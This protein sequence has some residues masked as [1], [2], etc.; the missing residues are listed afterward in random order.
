MYSVQPGD[1][2]QRIARRRYGSEQYAD[3]IRQA[4]P[5][6]S[7]PL[8][9]G[10]QLIIPALPDTPERFNATAA[11]GQDQVT[12]LIDDV[13]VSVWD[14]I[15]I[16][17]TM[18]SMDVISVTAP[19]DADNPVHREVFRPF[20]YKPVRILIGG[21]LAFK[22]TM[23]GVRPLLADSSKTVTISAYSAPGVLEDC[24]VSPTQYPVE[25]DNATLRTIAEKLMQPF[26]LTVQ[27][28][29]DP[30]A[31]FE[32]VAIEPTQQ[33]MTFLT[34]LAQQR[35]LLITSTPGGA[36]LFQSEVT[37]ATP[38]AKLEQGE[39]PLLRVTPSFSEQ[40][41]YSHLT[42]IEWLVVGIAG[43]D[44]TVKNEKLPGVMRPF[45][46]SVDDTQ[47][48]DVQSVV[49][50][51]AGRMLANAATYGIEVATWRDSAHN[52]WTPNTLTTLQAPGAMVYSRYTFLVRS[53]TL[54]ASSNGDRVAALTL[55]LPGSFRGEIPEALPWE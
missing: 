5:G 17:R 20:S 15:S 38:V 9:A 4:N 1:T 18:D 37:G 2:F 7:D 48:G 24:T 46:F 33:I 32:R 27:F 8:V 34:G 30:G 36:L 29:A 28:D 22:G 31:P 42:G 43:S 50:A 3:L 52:L 12:L 25:F 51:K 14:N 21:E 44:Y 10:T 45:A 16:T 41:Y 53:V 39:P 54:T 6:A 19:F 23:V 49:E 13:T 55:V 47:G 35:G 11:G 26:G 40:D